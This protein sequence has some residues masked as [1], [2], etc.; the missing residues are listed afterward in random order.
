[1]ARSISFRIAVAV[2]LVVLIAGVGLVGFDYRKESQ[3]RFA[4]AVHSLHEQ[5]ATIHQAI[6]DIGRASR[7]SQQAFIDAASRRL[8]G[9]SGH[10]HF[11]DVKTMDGQLLSG[12]PQ[13]EHTDT[14]ST[15]FTG[16]EKAFVVGTHEEGGLSVSVSERKSRVQAEI[17][18]QVVRRLLGLTAFV[19]ILALAINLAI[20]K[21]VHH[22]LVRL[23]KTIEAIAEGDYPVVGKR[24]EGVEL[25]RLVEAVDAMSVSLQQN[26]SRR[27]LSL[28][29]ARRV[30]ANLLPH[31][32]ESHGL[33]MA[34]FYYPAE[35][36][37]GDFF[38]AFSTKSG[39]VVFCMADVVGHGIGAAMIA[40]M[41][42]ALLNDAA[43]AHEHP[44]DILD[45]LNRRFM[46]VNLEEDFVT[47]FLATW[48][49]TTRVLTYVSAGHEPAV[50]LDN[51]K[52]LLLSSTGLPLG[53]DLLSTWEAEQ[54]KICPGGVLA[55]WTDGVTDAQS[56]SG[57]M[58]GR[59]RM[60]RL[61]GDHRGTSPQGF[62]DA[63]QTAVE[64][65][66]H[67]TELV[68]DCTFMA[69]RFA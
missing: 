37:A 9:K 29:R 21:L 69:V 66:S 10:H 13:G 14:A 17:H 47:L 15:D 40:A 20:R 27:Q 50:L 6:A 45:H 64:L 24:I 19:A 30:Q 60:V 33:E 43:E 62:V 59:N 36:I 54:I 58:L 28:S 22:P 41:L 11:I 48:N 53:V 18:S 1:M 61:A 3:Q 12:R 52:D 39:L 57:E 5:A 42:K 4:D 63:V 67:S 68:D 25:A 2:N 65:H 34:Y 7:D 51:E 23:A 32:F 31:D 46:A 49:P 26:E 56:G 8:N 55:C 16:N 44:E 38:D 35:E